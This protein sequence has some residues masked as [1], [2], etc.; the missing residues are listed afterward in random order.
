[1]NDLRIALRG[2]T[3]RPG[4]ALGVALTLGLG[5]GA[6]TAVSNGTPML[7]KTAAI[8]PSM[9]PSPPGTSEANESTMPT[10][11]PTITSPNSIE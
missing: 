4:F 5:V 11:K 9:M 10:A 3:R 6:T 2:L 7:A 8:D 1:M